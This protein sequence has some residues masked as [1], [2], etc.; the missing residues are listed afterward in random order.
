MEQDQVPVENY[1]QAPPVRVRYDDPSVI[2]Y[3]VENR[4]FLDSFSKVI[5]GW[6]QLPNVAT[7]ELE[8]TDTKNPLINELGALFITSR[9][10]V[11]TDKMIYLSNYPESRVRPILSVE[12]EE[13]AVHLSANMEVYA[14]TGTNAIMIMDMARS[15]VDA[16][17]RRPINDKERKHIFGSVEESLSNQPRNEGKLFGI[18]PRF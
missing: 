1:P 14:L 8:W 6:A 5:R 2:K 16:A 13:M 4:E 3:L 17:H 11:A 12:F 18:I 10:A 15:L 9:L 7:G